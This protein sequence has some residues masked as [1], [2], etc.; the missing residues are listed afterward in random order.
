[1]NNV[2]VHQITSLYSGNSREA[3]FNVD[4]QYGSITV[5]TNT[6]DHITIL[7][8]QGSVVYL[9]SFD[10]PEYFEDWKTHEG[11]TLKWERIE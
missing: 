4:A 9:R 5:W 11:K 6:H 10:S 8:H 2:T 1:M 7:I 3:Y